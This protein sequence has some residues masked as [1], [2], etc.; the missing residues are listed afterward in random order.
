MMSVLSTPDGA[1]GFDRLVG[2]RRIV[3][4]MGTVFTLDLR[5][6]DPSSWQADEVVAWWHWVDQTFSTYRPDSQVSRLAA[7]SLR[8]DG[9]APEVRHM[10]DL[11][12][13]AAAASCSHFTDR[14]GGRLDPSGMVKGWS[15]EVASDMLRQAGSEHRCI[16]AGGDVSCAGVPEAGDVWR[17]G[18]VDP[19]DPHR[20]LAVVARPEPEG[21][22]LAVATSGTAE[23]GHHIVDPVTGAAAAELASVTVV[24]T[25]LTVADWTATAAFA[26]GNDSRH[27]LEGIDGLEAYVV[28]AEGD[29]WYTEGFEKLGKIIADPSPH[30]GVSEH[31]DES[32]F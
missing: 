10:L 12:E 18:V 5:D 15:V 7:G 23:R 30:R 11:C 26:M 6:L 20:L 17:V 21:P 13:R 32:A 27:W 25:G 9:C 19:F 1:G 4:V 3:T 8:L 22:Q 24:G 2:M 14:P 28:T 29:Y 31:P 16:T